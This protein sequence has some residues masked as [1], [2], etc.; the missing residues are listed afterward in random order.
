MLTELQNLS[1]APLKRQSSFGATAKVALIGIDPTNTSRL[2]RDHTRMPA[3]LEAI[4]TTWRGAGY[5]VYSGAIFGEYF[6]SS[7]RSPKPDALY[8]ASEKWLLS[9]LEGGPH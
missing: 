2:S 4:S 3:A 1:L 8:R 9:T 6:W 7:G 5:E